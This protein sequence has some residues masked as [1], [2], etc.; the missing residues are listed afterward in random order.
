VGGACKKRNGVEWFELSGVSGWSEWLGRVE[1]SEVIWSSAMWMS[2]QGCADECVGWRERV[3][4]KLLRAM[5]VEGCSHLLGW[6][7]GGLGGNALG[8]RS[9]IIVTVVVVQGRLRLG[10][11]LMRV[12][13]CGAVQGREGGDGARE[14]RKRG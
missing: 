5:F 10:L 12:S 13:A 3:I 6:R 4:G 9:A 8:W 2:E 11:S 7:C 14:G 1:K